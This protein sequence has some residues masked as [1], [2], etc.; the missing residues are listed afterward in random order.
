MA[1]FGS[2]KDGNDIGVFT[3]KQP[4]QVRS[5]A[6]NGGYTDIS[7]RKQGTKKVHIFTGE[8]KQVK[9]SKGG[10]AWMP[11]KIWK[12]VVKKLEWRNWRISKPPQQKL[13]SSIASRYVNVNM[14]RSFY[15]NGY[16][17]LCFV[18]LFAFWVI[19]CLC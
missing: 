5:K 10:P 4:R 1:F 18:L 7:L 2:A 17:F 15:N 3:G 9:K 8:R 14:L 11:D 6:A 19:R 16:E 12:P 13:L